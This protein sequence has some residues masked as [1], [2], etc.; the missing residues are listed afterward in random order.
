MATVS[1]FHDS[2]DPKRPIRLNGHW[3]FWEGQRLY[4]EDQE[5]SGHWED[6]STP[7]SLSVA[8]WGGGPRSKQSQNLLSAEVKMTPHPSMR[9]LA[10]NAASF[11]LRIH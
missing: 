8:P 2:L 5:S 4:L 6:Q 7:A 11:N 3:C 10:G 9:G 1:G